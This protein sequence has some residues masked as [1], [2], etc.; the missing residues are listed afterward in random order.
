MSRMFER[1]LTFVD[2]V[3]TQKLKIP[4]FPTVNRVKLIC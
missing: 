4:F 2:Y 1:G 3:P